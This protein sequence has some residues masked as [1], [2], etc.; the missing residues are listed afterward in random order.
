MNA[1][2]RV[3]VLSHSRCGARGLRR[4]LAIFV[5]G[6]DIGDTPFAPAAPG[7]QALPG[8]AAA[9]DRDGPAA[10]LARALAGGPFFSHRF[11]LH[12]PEFNRA[13]LDALATQ[14][15]R[16]VL[17]ERA[18]RVERI[19]SALLAQAL[20]LPTPEAVAALRERL[21]AGAATVPRFAPARLDAAVRDDGASRRWLAQH[22]PAAGRPA[23]AVEFDAL[24]RSGLGAL[25]VLDRLVASLGLGARAARLNDSSVL[26]A[27]AVGG[28]HTLSLLQHA[29]GLREAR[30]GIAARV[31][32]QDDGPS[33]GDAVA[34]RTH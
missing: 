8:F 27:I 5:A 22:L 30:Q 16:T 6:T 18:S 20:D 13:L 2:P 12:A 25:A 26:A 28:C 32:A 15:Y 33:A 21:R 9:V 17:I 23:Q 4:L 10:A 34:N 1:P 7:G 31:A 11:D 19:T 14:G 3:A 29:S 24:F